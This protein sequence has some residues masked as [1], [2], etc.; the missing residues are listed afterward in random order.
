MV[1]MRI[2][3]LAAVFLLILNVINC[4]KKKLKK[5]ITDYTDA[6][7]EKIYEEWEVCV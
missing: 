6:E 4:E 7:I 5:D 2:V 3:V 1:N